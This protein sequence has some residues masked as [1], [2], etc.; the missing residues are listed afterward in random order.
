[1]TTPAGST[2][3]YAW[4]GRVSTEDEQDPTLSFPRQLQNA[5]RQVEEAGGRIVAHYYDIESGTRAYAARGSGGLAGFDIPI[6]RDG[7]LQDLLADAARRPARFDRVIVESISRLSRNS[8]VAFRVED[9]LRQAGVRLCAA[10]E[11]M[12][13][14][15]GTIVLR[16]VNIGIARG[17]H[18]ELMVKSRQG[19]ETSTRQ[20]WHT[21]GVALYG[22]RFVTHDHPNPHKANRGINKRT[23]ELDPVRAPVVRTIYDWYLG[24]G[25]GLLQIRD[26]LNA[27]PERYPPPVPVDPATARGAWSRSSVWEVLRNP[28]YTGYQ[29]WNRRARKQG[30]NRTNPP[31]AWIWSEEPAHPAIVTREEHDAVQARARANERSRQSVPATVARPTAKRDYLYRGLLRCGICGLRMWGNHRRSST[32]YSC[33]PSHQRSKDIPADHP[34]HVYLNEERLNAALLPFLATALFGPERTDYWRHA[35]DA[36]AEPER[37]APARERASE[38]EAEIA[39]LER[40]IGRQLVNLEADDVTPAL[41]R[42]VSQRLDELET[43]IAD[44]RERL[45]ALARASAT[46]TPTLADVAPLLDRLPILATR[47]DTAPQGELRALFDALQLD[48]VYQPAE[49]AVDV[50]VTLYDRGGTGDLA[51]QVRAEDWWAPPAL[52]NANLSTELPGAVLSLVGVHAKVRRDG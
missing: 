46:E 19:Q 45:V 52:H 25:V 7:G 21:G 30:H 11:P 26:R 5:E 4:Y 34:P 37:T 33:Q 12:E 24:G 18:H 15:F 50:A 35:L 42:R 28:K 31:E 38:I 44:R 51:A 20:G 32:Y 39:D 14:S 17:Y 49:S 6:P 36:T 48:V 27:E 23:L 16:H 40:R 43:S 3:R 9:E 22:Y 2:P 1:M 41:R 29:V 8:S 47:L 13:E 10:D